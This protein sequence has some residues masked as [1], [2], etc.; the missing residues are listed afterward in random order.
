MRVLL[1]T[2]QGRG[3]EPLVGPAVRL[4]A[5]G[6]EVRVCVP[7]DWSGGRQREMR[8]GRTRGSTLRETPV[9]RPASAGQRSPAAPK[10]SR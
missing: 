8:T 9:I 7:P 10:A 4:G 1:L 3:D 6:A 2:D 5:L